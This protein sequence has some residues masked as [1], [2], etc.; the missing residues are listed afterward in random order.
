MAK[1]LI[2]YEVDVGRT[3]AAAGLLAEKMRSSGISV[4]IEHINKINDETDLAGY[5]AIVLGSPTVLGGM[6]PE[7]NG[8]FTV[9]KKVDLE[10]T[11]GGVFGTSEINEE[12]PKKAFDIM[13][14]EL[15]M[16]M[17]DEPLIIE[18]H[19][20]GGEINDCDDYAKKIVAKLN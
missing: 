10:S 4:T 13:K 2:A 1:I 5:D 6:M 7:I 19:V 18:R 9:A 11:V 8:F 15:K 3:Q 12:G 14:N 17:V 20:S 16:E